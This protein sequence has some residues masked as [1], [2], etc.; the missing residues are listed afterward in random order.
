MADDVLGTA[1]GMF[2]VRYT[3]LDQA[4]ILPLAR[5]R[6]RP[7]WARSRLPARNGR[8][9][10]QAIRTVTA[11]ALIGVVRAALLWFIC[12]TSANAKHQL[13]YIQRW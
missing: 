5:I 8:S 6:F 10:F 4:L 1:S 9:S 11:D 3:K 12:P 7:S 2:H 13:I